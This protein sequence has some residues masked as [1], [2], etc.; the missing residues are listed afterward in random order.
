MS[1]ITSSWERISA[2]AAMSWNEGILDVDLTSESVNGDTFVCAT[3]IPNMHPYDG[4]SPNSVVVMDNCS[5]HHTTA[6]IV[7]I[8]LPPYSPDLNQIQSAF[9]FVKSYL[10]RHDDVIKAFPA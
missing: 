5:N 3:L 6:G 9:G 1:Q 7:V 10:K 2:I 4:Q 8:Y